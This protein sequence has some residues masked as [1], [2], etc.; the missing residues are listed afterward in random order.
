MARS[1]QQK[2]DYARA[3]YAANRE[4]L[5]QKQRERDKQRGP[6]RKGQRLKKRYGITEAQRD[7]MFAA[8][9]SQCAICSS[10]DPIGGNGK[11]HVDHCH[12]TGRVRG[13]L[14]PSCNIGLGKF[15]DSPTFLSKAIEYLNDPR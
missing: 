7:E 10:P 1:A 8:Q 2:R 4:A 14:C 6:R 15:R 12:N 3:Y 13:V 11:W 9:G 5:R